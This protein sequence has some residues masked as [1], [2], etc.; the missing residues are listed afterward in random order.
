LINTIRNFG[1]QNDNQQGYAPINTA[2][3][4]TITFPAEYTSKVSGYEN[5]IFWDL[6]TYG[7]DKFPDDL[8]YDYEYFKR[9]DLVIVMASCCN[10]FTHTDIGIMKELKEKGVP[11]IMV[12]NKTDES[13]QNEFASKGLLK[14]NEISI[15]QKLQGINYKKKNK[16]DLIESDKK[17]YEAYESYIEKIKQNVNVELFT[18]HVYVISAH[19]NNRYIYEMP[20]LKNALCDLI[21]EKIN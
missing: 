17:L 4:G 12:I 18:N 16:I 21:S 6:P 8:H 15:S 9:Y 19:K 13:L 5:V 2:K 10:L 3:A 20:Q 7:M 1:P 14:S 11:M